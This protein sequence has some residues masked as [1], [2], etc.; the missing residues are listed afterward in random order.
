MFG[1]ALL[2]YTLERATD[3]AFTKDLT[4]WVL[5]TTNSFTDNSAQPRTAYFYRVA[6]VSASGR[7][8]ASATVQS[9][10][11]VTPRNSGAARD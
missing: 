3:A 9:L 1:A 11:P 6:A 10:A 5:G 8:D 2:G 4:T 7:S